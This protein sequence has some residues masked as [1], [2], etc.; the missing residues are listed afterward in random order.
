MRI[1]AALIC[2]LLLSL[3]VPSPSFASSD[4][5][6]AGS[7]SDIKDCLKNQ[8]N[9]QKG[10]GNCNENGNCDKNKGNGKAQSKDKDDDYEVSCM[11]IDNRDRRREC[12]ERRMD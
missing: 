6:N 10:K 5:D 7:L 8:D 2:T 12:L 3:S 9:E 11:K 4:C 1:L